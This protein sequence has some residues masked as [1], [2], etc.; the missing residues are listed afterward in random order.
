[1]TFT[2]STHLSSPAALYSARTEIAFKEKQAHQ[3]LLMCAAAQPDPFKLSVTR[4]RC[5][6]P[7]PAGRRGST[8]KFG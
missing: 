2:C 3:R 4:Q 5:R 7:L 1:M 8:S 6:G